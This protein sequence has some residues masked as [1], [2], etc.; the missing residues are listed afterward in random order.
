MK[1]R[2]GNTSK[3]AVS[4]LCKLAGVSRSGYYDWLK[5]AP[6]RKL[7]EEQ[8]DLDIKLI[9]I[10]SSVKGKSRRRTDQNG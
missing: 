7:R 3:K 6:T 8:D 10:Y 9:K 1:E 2:S 5:A 4:Y